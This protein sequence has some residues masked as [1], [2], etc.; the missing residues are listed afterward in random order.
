M[1]FD[2]S[3]KNIPVEIKKEEV[4]RYLGE[5][6]GITETPSEINLLIERLIILS[7]TLISPSAISRSYPITAKGE[8][9]IETEAFELPGRDIARLLKDSI[10]VIL[11]ATTIG[12]ELEEEIN[13]LLEKKKVLEATILDAIGSTAADTAMDY[14]NNLLKAEATRKGLSLTRRYS[15]GYGDFPLLIQEKLIEFSGGKS[16]GIRVSPSYILI[17]RKSVTAVIGVMKG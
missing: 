4:R 8:N 15:P 11:C 3:L 7:K 13:S 16:L 2:L 17:P 6:K 12:N 9:V 14:L 10:E 5:Y 1:S